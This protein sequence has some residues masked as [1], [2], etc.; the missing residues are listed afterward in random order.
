MSYFNIENSRNT[1]QEKSLFYFK[2]QTISEIVLTQN[3]HSRMYVFLEYKLSL[4]HITGIIAFL[5]VRNTV[6]YYL[7]NVVTTIK[8]FTLN[9][10]VIQHTFNILNKI[11][12]I[13]KTTLKFSYESS[14]IQ[15]INV[16]H[17]CCFF[18]MFS[19]KC[20]KYTFLHHNC[21][22]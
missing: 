10:V 19:S 1:L 18:K 7:V 16:L 4:Q 17:T 15:F 2:M 11:F 5:W 3:T 6:K 13:N 20:N 9:I 22:H 21:F 14:Q 8:L 12:V